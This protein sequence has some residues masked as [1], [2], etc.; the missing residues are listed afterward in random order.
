[1]LWAVNSTQRLWVDC[2]ICYQMQ[3]GI[4]IIQPYFR[5]FL[6]QNFRLYWWIYL[7]L[8]ELREARGRCNSF[9]MFMK[10][11]IKDDFGNLGCQYKKKDDGHKIGKIKHKII[12][13]CMWD[14]LRWQWGKILVQDRHRTIA[15]DGI[16]KHEKLVVEQFHG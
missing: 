15:K 10:L 3:K 4:K 7:H 14:G 1:M 9:D 13:W 2:E 11:N 8:K 5:F 16:M 12:L 6:W